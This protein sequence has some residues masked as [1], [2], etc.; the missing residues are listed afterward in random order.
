MNDRD[1]F[2]AWKAAFAV[3]AVLVLAGDAMA[4]TVPG[5]EFFGQFLSLIAWVTVAF[6]SV[7]LWPVYA[8]F[9][10]LRGSPKQ[11]ATTHGNG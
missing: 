7:M 6:S 5:P 4:Y 10:R 1:N 3:V 11:P 9:R 8:L 2:F